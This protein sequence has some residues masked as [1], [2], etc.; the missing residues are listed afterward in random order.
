MSLL[1]KLS[2]VGLKSTKLSEAEVYFDRE[3]VSVDYAPIVNIA[4]SGDLINGGLGSGVGVLAG[5]SKHFKSNT[6]L[7][8]VASYLKKY[9][10][11]I[12]LFYDSEFGAPPAYWA[13]FGINIDRVLHV[14]VENIEQIKF[15]MPQKLEDIKRKDKVIIFVDSIGNLASKK[16]KQDAIDGKATVDMTR[17]REIKSMFRI[18]TPM[19]KLRDIPAIFVAHTYQTMEMFSKAVVAGGTGIYYSADWIIIFGRQQEKE[20]D[21]LA[22]YNFILNIEKS[23]FVREKSKVPLTVLFKGGINRYSGMLDLAEDAG[24]VKKGKVGNSSGWAKVDRSTGEIGE[25][26]KFA[27]TQ[28]EAFLGKIMEDKDF[29]AYI[30]DRYQL[31]PMEIEEK[32]KEVVVLIEDEEELEQ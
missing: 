23:R 6:G 28:T 21:D 26:V 5:P 10:D 30:I 32:A 8:A 27:E 16:E 31:S 11:A 13:N 17:A 4:L 25:Y 9:K 12:C 1:E 18:V 20:K 19:I 29:N 14:P 22:G 7:M 3:V 2:K 24:F 15:D